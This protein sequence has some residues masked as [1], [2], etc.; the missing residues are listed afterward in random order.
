LRQH[1]EL[2][3]LLKGVHHPD[4]ARRA[5][6]VG[7]SGLIVSNH[8]GR[9]LDGLPA[10]AELLPGLRA[11]V[12]PAACVLVD[13]GIRRGTDVLKALALGAD[14]VLL[15]R[16]YMH[17]LA[18]GGALGVAR[19]LALLRDEF[20]AALALCGCESPQ[21]AAPELLF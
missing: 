9:V 3:L 20:I 2:P 8:G 6:E 15:G 19:A 17:A 1:T 4:D 16:P 7:A 21:K 13:G 18:A 12:G 14:A 11:A 10:T 5:M